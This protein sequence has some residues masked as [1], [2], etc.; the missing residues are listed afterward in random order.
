M[1]IVLEMLYRFSHILE[2]PHR[3]SRTHVYAYLKHQH[4]YT[5]SNKILN[6]PVRGKVIVIFVSTQYVIMYIVETFV[7]PIIPH[8]AYLCVTNR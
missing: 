8:A 1:A 3:E 6:T 5:R 4:H 7:A 2:F